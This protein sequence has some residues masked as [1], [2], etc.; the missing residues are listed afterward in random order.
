MQINVIGKQRGIYCLYI[1]YSWG[2][3]PVNETLET[4]TSS[5]CTGKLRGHL[6]LL[7]KLD[8]QLSEQQ[9][10]SE[11]LNDS[12]WK[13]PRAVSRPTTCLKEGQTWDQTRLSWKMSKSEDCS[14]SV[15]NLVWRLAVLRGKKFFLTSIMNF[16]LQFMSVVSCAVHCCEE[17]SS[18]SSI[19]SL[20]GVLGAAIKC[21]WGLVCSRLK[22]TWLCSFCLQAPNISVPSSEPPLASVPFL[23]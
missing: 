7:Q 11:S 18:I 21:P 1:Q 22:R 5:L 6:T 3:R 4:G 9:M 16:L 17:P 20:W 2:T 19:S 8:I 12:G 13:G 14:T 15:C 23:Y 10:L